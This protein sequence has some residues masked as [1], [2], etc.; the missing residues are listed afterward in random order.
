VK[1]DLE[2]LKKAIDFF[3]QEL[4]ENDNQ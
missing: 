3:K 4:F 1:K 2:P